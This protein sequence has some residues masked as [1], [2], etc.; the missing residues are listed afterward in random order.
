MGQVDCVQNH[1]LSTAAIS[2]KVVDP[3]GVVVPNARVS[4]TN[5]SGRR[6]ETQTDAEGRFRLSAA[7]GEY[8]FE[9]SLPDFQI[10]RVDVSLD[11]DIWNTLHP[12]D[13]HVILGLFG[14]YCPWVTTSKREIEYNIRANIKRS[15][16]SAQIN[17]TQ[18]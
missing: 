12:A 9:A 2:G 11:R 15:K 18:K 16:E 4:L 3:F 14:L 13:L 8:K 17:A 5:L 6:F 1:V 7:S 10:A